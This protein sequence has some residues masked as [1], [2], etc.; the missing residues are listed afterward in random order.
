M[1]RI[2]NGGKKEYYAC[3]SLF[4]KNV[5]F[6]DAN[7]NWI[8]INSV[9]FDVFIV[10]SALPEQEVIFS[11]L[12]EIRTA[13]QMTIQVGV[14]QRT[15]NSR[16]YA[17]CRRMTLTSFFY[18]YVSLSLFLTHTITHI[19]AVCTSNRSP[20]KFGYILIWPAVDR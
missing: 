20:H 5:Q 15:C 19:Y 13:V 12:L 14:L 17:R 3:M 9:I 1:H 11:H 8:N 10:T 16:Y 2:L 18:I 4:I 7:R 6:V